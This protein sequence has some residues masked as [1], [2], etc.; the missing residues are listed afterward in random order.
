MAVRFANALI[1]DGSGEAPHTGDVIVEGEVI[2]A[3][4][5]MPDDLADSDDQMIECHIRTIMP[6]L[7]EAH[8][9]ISFNNIASMESV[10]AIQ[11]E[12]HALIS[13]AN[14]LAA[15]AMV[16]A[17]PGLTVATHCTSPLGVKLC[18][19]H[20]VHLIYHGLHADEEARD[21]LEDARE[22]IF[23]APAVGLPVSML[24]NYKEHGLKW[25]AARR[26]SQHVL[27]LN[28][29]HA[30]MVIGCSRLHIYVPCVSQRFFS[31]ACRR[32]GIFCAGSF[33]RPQCM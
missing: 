20:G 26:R 14:A 28:A 32:L 4:G 3:T 31:G 33:S 15:I 5:R 8:C 16:A 12:D 1:I 27:V 11:P 17:A 7:T 9:H 23:V 24:R 22:R 25:G 18:V 6:G 29:T 21:K 2:R 19:E 30:N 13:L 10:V